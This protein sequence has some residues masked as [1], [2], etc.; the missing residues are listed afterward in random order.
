MN[1]AV[2]TR[3]DRCKYAD[4]EAINTICSNLLFMGKENKK[5]LITSCTAGEGKSYVSMQ[6]VQ[7]LAKR[8][9]RVVLVDTDFR[10]SKLINK[11]G[12][13]LGGKKNGLAHFLAGFCTMDDIVYE[14]NLDGVYL[15]PIGK[16][17]VNPIPLFD[18]KH[19]SVFLNKL[20]EYFDYVIVDAPPIG[21]VV[22]AA[23]VAPCCDGAVFVVKYNST[24]RQDL[25]AAKRQIQLSGCAILGCIINLVNFNTIGAKKYYGKKYY[26]EY[27]SSRSV[28]R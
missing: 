1:R 11:Y 6:I 24:R 22:D 14:T 28:R 13:E 18:G 17:V 15:V 8:N 26:T 2:I 10:R 12:V 16:S 9:K 4:T 25:I 3:I 7:N 27:Y 19:L 20:S 23:E 21:L 5:I